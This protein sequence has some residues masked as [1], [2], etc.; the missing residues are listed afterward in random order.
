M[1]VIDCLSSTGSDLICF[2]SSPHEEIEWM[3]T[4]PCI[5]GISNM[6]VF[7]V[8]IHVPREFYPANFMEVIIHVRVVISPE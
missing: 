5:A 4:I 1:L 7:I 3:Q 8:C 6:E 2:T